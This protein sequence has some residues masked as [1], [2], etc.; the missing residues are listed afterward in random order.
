MVSFLGSKLQEVES[1]S[2]NRPSGRAQNPRY[3]LLCLLLVVGTLTLYYPVHH[4]PFCSVD[5]Y[6]YVTGDAHVQGVLDWSN[7]K[8]A[9]THFF[10]ELYD[11]LTFFSHNLDV[12]MFGQD[13]GGHHLVNVILHVVNAL[14]LFW[15]LKRATGYTGRSFMVAA[16]FAVHPLQVENVAWISERKTLLSTLFFLLALLAYRWYAQQPKLPR[17]AVV[18]FLYGLGLLAKPQVIMLP[19]VLLLWDYWPLR[20]M[21]AGGPNASRGLNQ[22]DIIPPRNLV[23]LLV[24]KIPLFCIAAADAMLTMV[25]EHKA[26][27]AN[28]PYTFSIRLGNAIWSYARYVSKAFYPARLAFFYPHPGNTLRWGLVWVSLLFLIAV[29][30]L[31]LARS[32]ERYL[33]VGWFWFLGTLSPM[34]GIVQ[35]SLP[36]M[37]DRYAY[38]SFIGLF[39]MVCWG[40]AD[41]SKYRHVPRLA[42][43]VTSIVVLGIMLVVTHRQIEYWSDSVT[44]WT[45]TLAVTP[46]NWATELGIGVAY[47]RAGQLEEAL[48]HFYRAAQDRP[49]DADVNMGIA[50]VEHQ[51]GNLRLAI[52][53]YEKALAVSKDT[54]ITSQAWANLGHVYSDLGDS[55]RARE[56]YEALRPRPLPADSVNW[57]GD[58]W[59]DLG[60]YLRRRFR[61]WRS[62][63]ASSPQS[64]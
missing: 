58:W 55:A 26:S 9:F 63:Q 28:W 15:I 12:Q 59:R 5:D 3:L 51:R 43:P 36:A 1:V 48:P 33:A 22:D 42:L 44:L 57:Q 23:A 38:V 53:Y 41:W 19:F 17:M 61:E 18:A 11:P 13:A 35:I 6:L 60:P 54:R 64:R 39:L 52:P 47:Q 27:P 29:T 25:A 56:C 4:Y 62:G 14:L 37:A 34:I 8:W 45:H 10:V 50:L 46:R 32:R 7:V 30:T 16:L 31:V 24:E 40:V 49:N 21:F 20:R 2:H